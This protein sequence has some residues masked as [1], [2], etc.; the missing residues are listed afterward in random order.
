MA[1]LTAQTTNLPAGGGAFRLEQTTIGVFLADQPEHRL[2]LGSDRAEQVPLTAQQGW[3][4]PAGAEG[5]CEFD[6]PLDFLTVSVS[7]DVLGDL[8]LRDTTSL[9]PTVGEIDPLL[10]AMALQAE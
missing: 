3:I 8:G 1:K 9:A 2:A 6:R 4:M 10:L 5:I 7:D